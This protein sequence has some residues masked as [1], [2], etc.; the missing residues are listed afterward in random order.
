MY[1]ITHNLRKTRD[2]IIKYSTII[3][4]TSTTNKL[5]YDYLNIKLKIHVRYSDVKKI[6]EKS[7]ML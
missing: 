7:Y 5:K 1:Y 3:Y 2:L 6:V 4:N